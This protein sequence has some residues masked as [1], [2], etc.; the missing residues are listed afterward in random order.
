[1]P[2]QKGSKDKKERAAGSGGARE[3]S[4][5]M[6]FQVSPTWLTPLEALNI[7]ISLVLVLM[8]FDYIDARE[9]GLLHILGL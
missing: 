2:R 7:S 4:G 9:G 5:R 8:G 6:A 1:M 3:G